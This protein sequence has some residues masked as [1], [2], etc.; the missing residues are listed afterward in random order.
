M[1]ATTSRLSV[2]LLLL[3]EL[4]LVFLGWRFFVTDFRATVRLSAT[5]KYYECGYDCSTNYLFVITTIRAVSLLNCVKYSRPLSC[6][7]ITIRAMGDVVIKIYEVF[8][9]FELYE[10]TYYSDVVGTVQCHHYKRGVGITT[11]RVVL[12]L[13]SEQCRHY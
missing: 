13:S 3:F 4:V 12:A 5:D 2:Y 8:V 7:G 6:I 1:L 10:K 11:I 9:T